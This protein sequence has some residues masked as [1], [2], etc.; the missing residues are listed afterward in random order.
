VI[1]REAR[2]LMQMVETHNCSVSRADRPR[3][4]LAPEAL[5]L[6]PA[7]REVITDFEPACDG[8]A[9]V[10]IL[11]DL[12]ES[13]SA[14]VDRDALRTDGYQSSRQRA[15]DTVPPDRL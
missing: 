13:S 9:T 4:G 10:T 5:R 15:E 7:I 14:R 11:T 12:D 1:V 6:A 8:R 3:V 2:R